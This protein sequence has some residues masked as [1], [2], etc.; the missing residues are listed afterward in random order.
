MLTETMSA[1]RCSGVTDDAPGGGVED[2]SCAMTAR[3]LRRVDELG[4]DAA[5]ASVLGTAGSARSREHLRDP[6]NWISTRESAALFE[7]AARVTHRR[8]LG[9]AV[10][11]AA[12]RSLHAGSGD[13][14]SAV[15]AELAPELALGRLAQ[16]SA[17]HIRS[18][19]VAVPECRP[20]LVEVVHRPAERLPAGAHHCD[21]TLGLLEQAASLL[22]LPSARV[23]HE[24]CAAFGAAECRYRVVW[25]EQAGD[26]SPAPS[27]DRLRAELETMR[28]RLAGMFDMAAD[29]VGGG[30][31]ADSLQRI[32]ARAAAELG[33]ARHLLVVRQ[34]EGHEPEVHGDGFESEQVQRLLA[35]VD[36]GSAPALEPSWL[37]APIRSGG[38]DYGV[39]VVEP[40]AADRARSQDRELLEVYARYAAIAL[41]SATARLRAEHRFEQTTALLEFAREVSA[42]GTSA[43]VAQR[44]ADSVR[45]VVDCDEVGVH[46]W[47]GHEFTMIGYRDYRGL[48]DLAPELPLRWEPEPE[49]AAARLVGDPQSPPVHLSL[50]GDCLADRVNLATAGL[51]AAIAVPLPSADRLL[52]MLFVGVR[53][54]PERLR[55]TVELGAQLEGLAAHAT[56]TLQNGRLMDVVMQQARHDQLTGL[57]NRVAFADHL[58]EALHRSRARRTVVGVFYMDLDHFKPVNDRFGHD[59]GDELLIAVADRLAS[60]A[61]DEV[62]VARLG[63]DEF[64]LIAHAP[65]VDALE[66]IERQLRD[67]FSE[68]FEVGGRDLTLAVSVVRSVFPTEATDEDG[69]LR[70]ADAAMYLDKEVQ[71]LRRS[72]RPGDG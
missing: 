13:V 9:H 10:G 61:T 12:A 30:L 26:E 33:A 3:L 55:R 67:A 1:G 59:T 36:A 35:A 31:A 2:Y 66:G 51:E 34:G 32:A 28:E 52:G 47:E 38:D 49:E 57:P 24:T 64:A 27:A 48:R 19:T 43:Q 54:R 14:S 22:E 65:R 4:G 40:G 70:I 16:R 41:D 21:T 15:D 39:L 20:G 58:R 72:R 5:V 25:R 42:A 11:A 56:T 7:A 68:P 53:D 37:A 45:L 46:L 17:D 71:R 69:L 50:S 63:G 6:R 18:I 23:E 60:R 29:L 8:S 62:R 44:V